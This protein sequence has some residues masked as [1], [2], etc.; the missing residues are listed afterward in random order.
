MESSY[1]LPD[2]ERVLRHEVLVGVSAEVVWKAVYPPDG[3]YEVLSFLPNE[4]LSMRGGEK[5]SSP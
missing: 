2:G 3:K 4:M 5:R 1:V